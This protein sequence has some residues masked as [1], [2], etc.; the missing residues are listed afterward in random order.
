M[1][2]VDAPSYIDSAAS[3]HPATRVFEAAIIHVSGVTSSQ[4]GVTAR[5][6]LGESTCSCT[7]ELSS[8]VTTH[9]TLLSQSGQTA[10]LQPLV[11]N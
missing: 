4:G 11:W 5:M 9:F 8:T 2:D 6:L 10:S 3:W 1:E 7:T